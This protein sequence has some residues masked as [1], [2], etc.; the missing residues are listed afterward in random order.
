MSQPRMMVQRDTRRTRL[1]SKY[2]PRKA[3]CGRSLIRSN[4]ASDL[5]WPEYNGVPGGLSSCTLYDKGPL[6]DSSETTAKPGDFIREAVAEDLKAG[7]YREV[8]TRF[9]PEPNGYLHIGHAKAFCLDFGVA[10]E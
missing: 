7:R 4:P 9:P 6:M 5:F 2:V 3:R 10:Q 1:R 8:R